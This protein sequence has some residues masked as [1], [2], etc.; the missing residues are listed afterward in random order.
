MIVYLLLLKKK[1]LVQILLAWKLYV[2][3]ISINIKY[4]AHLNINSKRS[5]LDSL[6]DV[7]KDNIDILMISKTK[8]EDSF[9]DGQFFLDGFRTP[10]HLDRNRNGEGIMHFIRNGISAKAVSTHDRPI[11]SFYA[12]L[13]CRKKKWLFN[14]SY[15]PKHSSITSSPVHLFAI[16]GKWKRGFYR[17][18]Y[19]FKLL[20]GWGCMEV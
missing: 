1:N 11:E 6:A 20:W 16:R 13:N 17:G 7:I 19:F 8:S 9:P 4:F 14:C 12:E 3:I 15:N 18:F 10:F 2:R 5:K